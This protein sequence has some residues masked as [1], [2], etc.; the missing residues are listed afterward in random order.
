M[1]Q[2]DLQKLWE[3]ICETLRQVGKDDDP[4]GIQISDLMQ[5]S[6]VLSAMSD[7]LDQLVESKYNVS[8]EY[9]DRIKAEIK[10]RMKGLVI[11]GM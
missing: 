8:E 2:Q 11:N 5:I 7:I 4:A 10:I 1:N 3:S 6:G 9:I